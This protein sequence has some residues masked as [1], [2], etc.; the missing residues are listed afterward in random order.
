MDSSGAPPPSPLPPS[1]L[2]V[3]PPIISPAPRV[4]SSRL[5][6][7]P[8]PAFMCHTPPFSTTRAW[9]HR[10]PCKTHGRSRMDALASRAEHAASVRALLVAARHRRRPRHDDHARAGRHRV[11]G[12]LGG[13]GHQWPLRDHRAAARVRP[14]RSQPHHRS[15]P[16]LGAR[17]RDPRRRAAAFGGRS[18]TRGRGGRN[19]GHRFRRG[20]HCSGPGSTR[21]HH[22]VALEADPLRLHERHRADGGAEP[23]PE[24]LW[25]FGLR[26]RA[27]PAGVGNRREG[28]GGKHEPR[29]T[30][31]RRQHPRADPDPEAPAARPGHLDRRDRCHCCGRGIRSRNPIRHLRAR[32][33]ASRVADAKTSDR[34]RRQPRAGPHGRR[35][36]G[37]RVIRRHQCALSN[38][39]GASAH[40]STRTRRW[41]ASASPTSRQASSRAFRSAAALRAHRWPRR[42]APGPS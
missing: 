13:A 29:G 38:L 22:R 7:L 27:D 30:R 26:G 15:R 3:P 24:A 25:L 21:L 39:C 11:R 28:G 18:A 34:R 2:F 20:V 10:A 16:G 23:D 19:D 1:S 17:G 35:R 36:G 6:V 4:F 5:V 9:A 31:G 12:G 33:F 40:R 32:S 41:W 14:V 8:P 37:P 42:R